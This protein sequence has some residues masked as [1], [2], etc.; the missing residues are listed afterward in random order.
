[1]ISIGSKCKI[2]GKPTR[3][4]SFKVLSIDKYGDEKIEHS[5]TKAHYFIPVW[6]L[7]LMK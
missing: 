4:I 5:L 7:D 2:K 3:G 1:M 6:Q